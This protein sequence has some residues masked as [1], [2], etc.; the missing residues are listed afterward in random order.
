M[1]GIEKATPLIFL[2]I[3]GILG[4]NLVSA[5]VS[6]EKIVKKVF[7]WTLVVLDIVLRRGVGYRYEA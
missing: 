5:I 4:T 7:G 6:K 2:S 1:H 3:L